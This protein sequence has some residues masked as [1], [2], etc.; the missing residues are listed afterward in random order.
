MNEITF[1]SDCNSIEVRVAFGV[2]D[3]IKQYCRNS[4]ELETGGIL[5]GSYVENNTVADIKF[6]TGPTSD[7][8]QWKTRFIRGKK[9]LLKLLNDY[10][11][12]KKQYYIGDWHYHPTLK[13][14][15]SQ[16]DYSEIIKISKFEKLKCPEPILLIVAGDD[17]N[18]W[19]FNMTLVD[20]SG[21]LVNLDN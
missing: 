3:S 18:G 20:S 5:I 9:G 1:F 13:A 4:G 2:Y 8:K 6:C 17:N 14:F 12:Q 19:D 15:P 11:I 10:W 7:S 21:N 16:Q